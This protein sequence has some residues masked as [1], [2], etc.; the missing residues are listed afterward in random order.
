[1]IENDLVDPSTNKITGERVKNALTEMVDAMGTGG[2]SASQIEYWSFP[3]GLTEEL[4]ELALLS[5]LF[6]AVG[7]GNTAI[8]PSALFSI[9]VSSNPSMCVGLVIVR[10]LRFSIPDMG[11]TTIGEY[12]DGMGIDI[13]LFG[14][15]LV[16]EEE[17][18][19]I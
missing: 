10:N 13:T 17:F 19:T 7:N 4:Q 1:M 12:L 6:K 3:N 18:Y 16:T 14:G 9:V 15:V 11:D 5:S 8:Q 2:G